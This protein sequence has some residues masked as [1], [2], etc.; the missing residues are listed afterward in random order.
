MKRGVPVVIFII[1]SMIVLFSI[2]SNKIEGNST[3]DDINSNEIKEITSSNT[4]NSNH[5][6]YD[7]IT[8]INSGMMTTKNNYENYMPVS[9]IVNGEEIFTNNYSPHIDYVYNYPF[10][11][12]E[13]TD[14]DDSIIYGYTY[15]DTSSSNY[16]SIQYNIIIKATGNWD[17]VPTKIKYTNYIIEN[18]SQK[19]EWIDYFKNRIKENGFNLVPIIITESWEFEYNGV[20]C[21]AVNATN[22]QSINRNTFEDENQR[23]VISRENVSTNTLYQMSAIFIGNESYKTYEYFTEAENS[24]SLY[25]MNISFS[26]II[27]DK[28]VYK[29]NSFQFNDEEETILRPMFLTV[30]SEDNYS[31]FNH[32]NIYL[33]AD[34]DGDNKLESIFY[35]NAN[36]SFYNKVIIY[37][38]FNNILI[39]QYIE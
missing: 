9:A 39:P 32:D 20:K 13:H 36:D 5:K 27:G 31:F 15:Y 16:N 4:I 11:Y 35:H 28:N 3:S 2:N 26:P 19:N 8:F 37:E 7:S 18:T 14:I 10:Q 34:I 29:Y 6:G 38:I 12:N 21:A 23:S 25:G 1:L 30:N 24:N 33:F 22:V 17:F